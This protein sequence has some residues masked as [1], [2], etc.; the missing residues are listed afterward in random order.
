MA[1]CNE[2]H[3]Y[4]VAECVGVEAEG[5]VFVIAICTSCGHTFA[6]EFQVSKPGTPLR[7]LK[8]EKQTNNKE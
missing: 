3:R 4:F 6:K 2:L 1:S 7:M 5:K 8:E